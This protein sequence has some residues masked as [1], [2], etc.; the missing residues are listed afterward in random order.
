MS[1]RTVV[2]SSRCKLDLKMGYMVI[3]GEDVRRVFLDEIAVVMIENPAVS[4]TGCLLSGLMERKIKVI[5]C[6]NK[7]LPQGELVPHYGSH[8]TSRKIRTQIAWT[9]PIKGAVWG[10]IVAL[11]IQKQAEFLLETGHIQEHD[12]LKSYI[13][14]LEFQDAT[15]REGHAAKVYFNGIFGMDF[16]RSADSP[17][18]AALNYGYAILLSAFAREITA[19]GYLTQMGLHHENVFNRFN[20]ASDLMEPFRIL[21]DRAVYAAQPTQLDKSTKRILLD[22][23]NGYV[24]FGKEK[25]TVLNAIGSYA[26]S[27]F[28]ALNTENIDRIQCW[29]YEL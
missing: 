1:W 28:E 27:V 21:V 4:M 13:G 12:L 20:L 16:T 10:R 8:D 5:F 3:R 11:K 6:D 15:N 25:Q 14:Q 24:F 26:R 7:R 9:A 23:L 22:L 18:N 29:S 19:N 17:I 2:I